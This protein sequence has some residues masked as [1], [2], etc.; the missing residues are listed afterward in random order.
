M[1]TNN[2]AHSARG[3]RQAIGGRAMKDLITEA[4]ELCE[5]ATLGNGFSQNFAEIKRIIN[6]VRTESEKLARTKQ[7][8][9]CALGSQDET[10][11]YCENAADDYDCEDEGCSNFVDGSVSYAKIAE[12]DLHTVLETLPELRE[13]SFRG[14]LHTETCPDW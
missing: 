9:T 13:C 6:D 4:R 11:T 12:D 5:K 14:M 1:I 8:Y 2:P 7:C 3:R 10:G